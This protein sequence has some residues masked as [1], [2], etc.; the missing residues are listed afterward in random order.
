M[1]GEQRSLTFREKLWVSACVAL[2][3]TLVFGSIIGS[4]WV[5]PSPWY[6]CG[7]IPA[8]A[9]YWFLQRDSV[10]ETVVIF[11]MLLLFCWGLRQPIQSLREY[12]SSESH[13]KAIVI[14]S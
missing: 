6:L 11:L 8:T 2:L 4:I 1:D 9:I 7:A 10:V 5:L 13:A 14:E 3:G 12:I